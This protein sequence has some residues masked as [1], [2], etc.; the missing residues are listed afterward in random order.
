MSYHIIDRRANGKN[1]SIANRE[2]F[3]KRYRDY[4]KKGVADAIKNRNIKDLKDS[5]DIIIPEKQIS[6]PY[7]SH[8]METGERDRVHPGNKEFQPGDQI[9]K[10]GGGQGRGGASNSGEG[11]DDFTFTLSKEEFMKFFFEDL[12]LPNLVKK[13][14]LSLDSFKNVRAGW[15]TSGT[16]NNI[17]VIRSLR[18]AMGR[19]IAM[20][21]PILR[22]IKEV[23]E[24][25]K[26]DV[27]NDEAAEISDN[28]DFL[29]NRL[30]KVPFI[31]PLDIR[32]IN[33]VKV[34]QPSNQAVMF[35]LLDV[36]G[37]MDEERKDL[38][39]R[40]FILLYLFLQCN[41]DKIDIVFVR[42]HTEA[43]EVD[44]DTFFYSKESGG[45]IVSSALE[46][47]SKIINERY[48]PNDWNIYIAQA[49][50][51]DNWIS[52][53]S[54]CVKLIQQK[55]LPIVQ[56]FAYIQ[57]VEHEQDLWE[58]YS[59]LASQSENFSMKKV[60][61]SEEIYPVFRELFEKKD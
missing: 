55:L 1:K 10:P 14:L 34:P 52:D 4:I 61:S 53:S 56:Y 5:K 48:N 45:T 36:S 21:S 35:C 27:S 23:E 40:F 15:S 2:R 6:E 32:Y 28:L 54:V 13:K 39:K 47:T 22:K 60:S 59:E 46:L 7:F 38:S 31:D 19:R 58:K 29:S 43:S 44:E 30:K 57:V 16:P 17:D 8:D 37:S 51:G 41:Y 9:D 50:D 33:R 24:S 26:D 20:R 3:M 18:E 49:S 11:E 12:A 25:F 42:H